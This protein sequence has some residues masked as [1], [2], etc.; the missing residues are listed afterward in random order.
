MRPFVANA[1]HQSW[2]QAQHEPP[3]VYEVPVWLVQ[4]FDPVLLHEPMLGGR[5]RQASKP[6]PGYRAPSAVAMAQPLLSLAR[7]GRH[8]GWR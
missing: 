3:E 7:G 4:M 8:N 6:P 2:V 1:R 5:P